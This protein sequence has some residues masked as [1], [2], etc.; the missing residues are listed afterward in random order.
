MEEKLTK[1]YILMILL[2]SEFQALH[3]LQLRRF[4]LHPFQF[5]YIDK[6]LFQGAQRTRFSNPPHKSLELTYST[7]H[8]E[9]IG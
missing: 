2:R 9:N 4:I 7:F 1:E 3:I 5:P 8:T 6:A